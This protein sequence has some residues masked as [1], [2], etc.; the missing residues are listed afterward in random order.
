M[1]N[2][3][4]LRRVLLL[5]SAALFTLTLSACGSSGIS[6]ERRA[7]AEYLDDRGEALED[8]ALTSK[9]AAVIMEDRRLQGMEIHVKT[10]D[11]IVHLTGYVESRD[12]A[13]I[14]EDRAMMVRGVRAVDN[15]LLIR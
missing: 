2:T 4:P 11:N 10:F 8:A 5:S 1:T 3:L 7:E 15:D 9:V 14:A 12:D 6:N 13:H